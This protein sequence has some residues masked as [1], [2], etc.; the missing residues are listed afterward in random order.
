MSKELKDMSFK[1]LVAFAVEVEI[2]GIVE[3][4]KLSTRVYQLMNLAVAW[5]NQQKKDG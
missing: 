1:E 2:D 3:G 4:S 5:S